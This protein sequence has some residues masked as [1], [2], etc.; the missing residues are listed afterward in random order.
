MNFHGFPAHKQAFQTCG[1]PD[2]GQAL[3]RVGVVTH[4]SSKLG[5]A[6]G[7]ALLKSASEL[8]NRLSLVPG[9]GAGLEPV[10]SGSF[11]AAR[12]QALSV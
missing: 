11:A 6:K 3:P 5:K 9:H 4:A 12:M 10:L 7:N 8:G 2:S 1:P